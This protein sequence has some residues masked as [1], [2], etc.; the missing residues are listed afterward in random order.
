M[1]ATTRVLFSNLSSGLGSLATNVHLANN[2]S[3]NCAPLEQGTVH[4]W[5]R[6]A[7][8]AKKPALS[9]FKVQQKLLH[10]KEFK[11]RFIRNVGIYPVLYFTPH[12][13]L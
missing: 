4:F 10:P 7:N 6:A 2:I 1:L 11:S 3:S 13:G 8:T 9:F 12:G 5:H